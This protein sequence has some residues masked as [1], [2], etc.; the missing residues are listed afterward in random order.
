[1]QPDE[2]AQAQA[3]L[4]HEFDDPGLLQH[5]FRH[6]SVT[7]R[8]LDSNERLEFLGD[9]ILGMVVCEHIFRRYP[10]YLEGE[11]TKIKSLAVSR[12]TCARVA[13]GSGLDDLIRVGKGMRT[14]DSLPSSLSAAVTESVIAALYLDGGMEAVRRFLD[15]LIDPLIDEAERSGHQ[16]NFKSVLQQHA[17]RE[18]GASPS[19]EILDEKGPDHEKSFLVRVRI[20]GEGYEPC[21]GS[22]KKQAEQRAALRALRALGVL[23]DDDAEHAEDDDEAREREAVGARGGSD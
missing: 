1:M 16:H 22:S 23:K 13:T 15:P 18:L 11:M 5:A 9:A 12:A 10:Q 3:I 14:H 4:R 19:Y 20:D 8:R 17:Q 6:A 7:E 2:L 21:W